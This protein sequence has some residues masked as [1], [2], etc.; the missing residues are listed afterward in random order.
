MSVDQ[1]GVVRA[2]NV[3]LALTQLLRMGKAALGL[4]WRSSG[5]ILEWSSRAALTEEDSK[6]SKPTGDPITIMPPLRLLVVLVL[7]MVLVLGGAA[8]GSKRWHLALLMWRL[9]GAASFWRDEKALLV[10]VELPT[11]TTSSM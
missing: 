2:K 1:Q 8:L 7:V 3:G 9:R 6:D 10:S 5:M 11:S 4:R